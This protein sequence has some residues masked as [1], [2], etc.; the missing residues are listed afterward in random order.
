MPVSAPVIKTTCVL[1]L[2]SLAEPRETR[3]RFDG[4]ELSIPLRE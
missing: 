3:R 4:P 2:W 1:I